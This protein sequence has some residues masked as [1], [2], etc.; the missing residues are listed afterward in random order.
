[1][2]FRGSSRGF[3]VWGVRFRLLGG[4]VFGFRMLGSS[5]FGAS[6]ERTDGL[7]G[8]GFRAWG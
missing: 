8:V 6:V 7:S 2:V 4:E 5:G 1:M 3:R